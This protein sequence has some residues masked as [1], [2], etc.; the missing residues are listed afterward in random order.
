MISDKINLP[1][2]HRTDFRISSD[3]FGR[4]ITNLGGGR[5]PEKTA[6]TIALSYDLIVDILFNHTYNRK[7]DYYK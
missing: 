5:I 7:K 6:F 3:S 1:E 2:G 4:G